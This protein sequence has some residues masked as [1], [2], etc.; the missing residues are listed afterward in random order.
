MKII[1]RAIKRLIFVIRNKKNF[2]NIQPG[3][4]IV[5]GSSFEGHNYIG[6]YSK[7]KGTMG[8]GSYIGDNCDINANI[9]RFSCI[10]AGT[11]TIN[12]FHPTKD[13]VS[14]HP[15]FFSN[16][17]KN[18]FSYGINT[19]FEEFR[20]IDPNK[21][22]WT[23]I[24]ND[25]WVGTNVMILSGIS[26]GDGAII[27]A[28]AVVVNDIEPYAI[29]GGV[30]ARK[31]GQRFSDDLIMELSQIRWWDKSFDWIKDNA[32]YFGNVEEFVKQVKR[33]NE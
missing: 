32:V 7:F 11:Q 16:Q 22:I 19:D 15:A 28:G 30:P 21:K 27:A 13:Y 24:G 17:H 10:A 4:D 25:V 29:Y 1:K 8:Y 2:V 14:I 5:R 33:E 9:G 23:A 12:G 26:I 20:Y 31:I 3:V 6:T 18:L